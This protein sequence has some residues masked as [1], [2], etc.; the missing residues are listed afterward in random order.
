V[1]EQLFRFRR[2][3]EPSPFLFHKKSKDIRI[4]IDAIVFVIFRPGIIPGS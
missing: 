4:A 2:C 1:K 3:T